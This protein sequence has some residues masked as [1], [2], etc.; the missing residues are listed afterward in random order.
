MRSIKTHLKP[1]R[2]IMTSVL[3]ALVMC[4]LW[5]SR[6]NSLDRSVSRDKLVSRTA[7]QTSEP[8][9][10]A[11]DTTR[12][13][14]TALKPTIPPASCTLN[15]SLQFALGMIETGVND[16]AVGSAGEVSRYQI[17][18]SVWK[19]Y[20]ESRDYRNPALSLE[21]ARKHW[22]YLH[23]YFR[24]QTHREPTDFDM[25]VLWNT[26]FGYYARKGFDPKHLN[27]T[28]FDR[29]QRFCNLVELAETRST[30]GAESRRT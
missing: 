27:R 20:S 19:K 6:A 26:R 30:S 8:V 24:K 9:K 5:T 12:D 18:P 22:V 11:R 7:L 28:V 29:A 14:N 25:Y 2:A 21:V 1:V 23:D 10:P 4:A 16:S 3:A 13:T 17:M 15:S